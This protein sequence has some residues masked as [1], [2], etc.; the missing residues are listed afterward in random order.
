MTTKLEQWSGVILAYA[1]LAFAAYGI[2][3]AMFGVVSLNAGALFGL[4][5]TIPYLVYRTRK[6][7]VTTIP[8]QHKLS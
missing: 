7:G 2:V 8:Y 6:D 1:S 5:M 3:I 4:G